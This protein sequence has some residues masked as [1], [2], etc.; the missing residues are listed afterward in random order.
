MIPLRSRRAKMTVIT[1]KEQRKKILNLGLLLAGLGLI[2]S[3]A[4]LP[5]KSWAADL[6]PKDIVTSPSPVIAPDISFHDPFAPC[7]GDCSVTLFGGHSA[8]PMS[9]QDVLSNVTLPTEWD[10]GDSDIAGIY[11]S[12]PIMSYKDLFTI[13]TEIGIA[14]RFGAETET[15][16][17]T[18][19]Y[20]RWRKFPWNHIV[21][22]TIGA[23]IGL[24]Y[25]TGISVYEKEKAATRGSE[26]SKLLHFFSPELTLAL[27]EQENVEL[28]FR[29]HHRSGVWGTFN[30]VHG[31]SHFGTVGIRIKF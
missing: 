13:D 7:H 4:F 19:L 10:W 14:K 30:G 20:L 21:K 18:A 24:N 12:R 25:A 9:M 22:T 3:T 31:G 16:Y 27:P 2:V 15:E 8:A 11:F 23:S 6:L 17:W 5:K 28:V 29:F 1:H 26:G